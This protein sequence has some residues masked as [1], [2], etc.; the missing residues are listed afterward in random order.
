MVF[1][2]ILLYFSFIQNEARAQRSCEQEL[3]MPFNAI[4][5]RDHPYITKVFWLGAW[6]GS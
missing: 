6:V 3:A 5:N 2:P 1:W 4:D